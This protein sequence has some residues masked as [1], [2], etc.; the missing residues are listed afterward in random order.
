M[1]TRPTSFNI[2]FALILAAI[3]GG[4]LIGCKTSEERKQSKEFSTLRLYLESGRG[5]SFNSGVSVYRASPIRLSVDREPFLTEVDLQ[6]AA[7][8]EL[9]GGYGIQAQFN[10]HGALVLEGVTVGHKGKHIVVQS[11]F[12]ES[13]WLA[14]PVITRRISNGEF[15]FTP[16][17]SREESERIVRGLTNVIRKIKKKSG[18][19]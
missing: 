18:G 7:L 9:P 5:S 1:M 14:A 15:V 11:H 2:Y 19:F 13:R 12:T 4:L 3:M 6:S 8:V 16:D 10:G 17:A